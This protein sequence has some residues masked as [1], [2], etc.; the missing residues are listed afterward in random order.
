MQIDKAYLE[1]HGASTP[2][3]RGRCTSDPAPPRQSITGR[4]HNFAGIL[5]TDC[6]RV[7]DGA[8]QVDSNDQASASGC[9]RSGRKIQLEQ[10][11]A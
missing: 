11:F 7:C 1:T 3:A 4:C 5:R 9:P 8:G 6:Y 10:D 2:A